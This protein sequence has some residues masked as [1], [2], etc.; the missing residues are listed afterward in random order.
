[1]LESGRFVHRWVASLYLLVLSTRRAMRR[2]A[3]GPCL[4]LP[5]VNFE[6]TYI[7]VVCAEQAFPYCTIRNAKVHALLL[8]MLHLE[9]EAVIETVNGLIVLLEPLLQLLGLV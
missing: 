5:I 6:L 2:L 3:W 1:M 4:E 7:S 8:A 9:D